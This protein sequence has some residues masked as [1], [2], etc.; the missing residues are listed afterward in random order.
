MIHKPTITPRTRTI[1]G[2]EAIDYRIS[3]G[4]NHDGKR[5]EFFAKTKEAAK[6]RANALWRLHGK[7]GDAGLALTQKQ[8][9]DA[10]GAFAV[11][12][13]K[14]G[15]VTL[16]E[17][18]QTYV[19]KAPSRPFGE[20]ILEY[21]NG[22]SK[23]LSPTTLKTT[24]YYLGQF[25]GK[26]D[27]LNRPPIT[28]LLAE[29]LV[30]EVGG[31]NP[32]TR[33]NVRA[34]L[35]AFFNW[36]IRKGYLKTN[37]CSGVEKKIV[38]YKQP[39]FFTAEQVEAIFREAETAPDGHHF[40]PWLVLGFF[41][42]LRTSEI[43]RLTWDD[44]CFNNGIV[45]IA[46]PKGYTRGG[47]PRFVTLNETAKSWFYGRHVTGSD[48]FGKADDF[49]A[50]RATLKSYPRN[51]PNAMRHTFATMHYA[52]HENLPLTAKEMGHGKNM[53]TTLEHYAGLATKKDA[54]KFWALRP[55]GAPQ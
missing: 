14:G 5:L 20:L 9:A 44:I 23:D 30:D 50:W 34:T 45:R 31:E 12:A 18:A 21:R 38:R 16:T 17:L 48:S 54:E 49:H 22:L 47:K 33:N 46:M 7:H 19:A 35:N 6:T 25:Y 24:N 8:L 15:G 41:C 51:A 13:N 40:M 36:G 43:E 28:P 37:F 55:K 1:K 10:A 2:A 52:M 42:G 53:D 3:L 11:L 27:T 32:K 29:T 4:T 39:V 26:W